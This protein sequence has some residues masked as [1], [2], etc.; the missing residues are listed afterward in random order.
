[1][2]QI[3]S[4]NATNIF[5]CSDGIPFFTISTT[6]KGMFGDNSLEQEQ[7][8]YDLLEEDHQ[9][10]YD[11]FER[12]PWGLPEQPR[13]VE[14]QASRTSCDLH[15]RGE[16]TETLLVREQPSCDL[17]SRD[18]PQQTSENLMSNDNKVCQVEYNHPVCPFEENQKNNK[19]FKKACR[20][21]NWETIGK[22]V[23]DKK[24]IFD[25]DVGLI[26]ACEG[27]HIDVAQFCLNRTQQKNGHSTI[28]NSNDIIKMAMLLAGRN[29]HIPLINYLNSVGFNSM[30]WALEGTCSAKHKTNLLT[31]KSMLDQTSPIFYDQF[32]IQPALQ[33]GNWPVAEF[34]YNI[35]SDHLKSRISCLHEYYEQVKKR[36]KE[37]KTEWRDSE[38]DDDDDD[39]DD[40][41]DNYNNYIEYSEDHPQISQFD[42]GD[43]C[44]HDVRTY[45]QFLTTERRL[46]ELYGVDWSKCLV[47]AFTSGRSNVINW[48]LTKA[49]ATKM[50]GKKL[51]NF[52]RCVNA[53]FLSGKVKIIQFVF[54]KFKQTNPTPRV[55]EDFLYDTYQKVFFK[56]GNI[57]L[58]AFLLKQANPGQE[59]HSLMKRIPF[60]FSDTRI[61]LS[62]FWYFTHGTKKKITPEFFFGKNFSVISPYLD[63]GVKSAWFIL[64]EEH[65][66][67]LSKHKTK[68]QALQY[69]LKCVFPNYLT[70]K[71]IF[72]F[73]SA[74]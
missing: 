22:M 54:D 13:N 66:L 9:S 45:E 27:G 69:L 26:G 12:E 73:V 65:S 23:M 7:P 67:I 19:L 68:R 58:V 63:Y 49:K 56:G 33:K 55:F 21:G 34:V 51:W 70:K 20:N 14:R 60:H 40:E 41:Y 16:F 57:H 52:Q 1:M 42:R 53:A 24:L 44:F 28:L 38:Y 36:K 25:W 3:I 4:I 46:N 62:V 50:D 35:L 30:N 72:P 8:D 48:V 71:T 74:T 47:S 32:G 2:P 43:K 11:L 37:K 17:H 15:S 29:G 64:N 61:L 39:D 18:V 6:N 5:Q 10:N 59:R 31:I